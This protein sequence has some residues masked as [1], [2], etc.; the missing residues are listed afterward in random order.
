MPEFCVTMMPD[1]GA[2]KAVDQANGLPSGRICGSM[3]NN[4]GWE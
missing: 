4:K 2:L 3:E 1:V